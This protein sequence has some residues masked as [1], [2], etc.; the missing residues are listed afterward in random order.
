MLHLSHDIKGMLKKYREKNGKVFF[1]TEKLNSPTIFR[2]HSNIRLS[3]ATY[4]SGLQSNPS[5][6]TGETCK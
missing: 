6:M 4:H 1:L 3:K 5:Q 2:T